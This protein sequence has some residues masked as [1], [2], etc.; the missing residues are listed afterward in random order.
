[1]YFFKVFQKS[2]YALEIPIYFEKDNWLS[3]P[4]KNSYIILL[5]K[6][7]FN[8]YDSWDVGIITS[9]KLDFLVKTLFSIK[10]FNFYENFWRLKILNL[11]NRIGNLKFKYKLDSL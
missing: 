3:F 7:G 8:S 1:M 2:G 11:T 10:S 6:L 4:L 5:N 9:L